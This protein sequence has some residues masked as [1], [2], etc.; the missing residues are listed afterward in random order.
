MKT[1]LEKFYSQGWLKVSKGLGKGVT[2][3]YPW[4]SAEDRLR[5]GKRLYSDFYLSGLQHSAIPD[6]IKPRVDGGK[7]K[8]MTEGQAVHFDALCRALRAIPREFFPVVSAIVL[9]DR[10]IL[11]P[12]SNTSKS[13]WNF[14]HTIKVQLCWGLDRLVGHYKGE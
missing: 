8:G 5:A 6:L 13:A 2:S 3:I 1:V 10:N 4:M 11:L 7:N 9:D 12:Q 14:N